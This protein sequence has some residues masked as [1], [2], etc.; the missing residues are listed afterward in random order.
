[1]TVDYATCPAFVVPSIRSGLSAAMQGVDYVVATGTV[2]F[3]PGDSTKTVTVQLNEDEV[4][5]G[6]ELFGLNLSNPRNAELVGQQT[7]VGATVGILDNDTRSVMISPTRIVLTEPRQGATSTA[8]TTL[9][10]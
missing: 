7:E 10:Y 5:E 3:R 9:W 1:M 4:S 2:T 8:R 6:T